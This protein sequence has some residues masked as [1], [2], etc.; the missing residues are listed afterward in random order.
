MTNTNS[1]FSLIVANIENLPSEDDFI[2]AR[3]LIAKYED[4]VLLKS[5]KSKINCPSCNHNQEIQ[6]TTL[7]QYFDYEYPYGLT[8]GDTYHFRELKEKATCNNCG[9]KYLLPIE[10]QSNREYTNRKIFKSYEKISK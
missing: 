3:N 7:I 6:D 9:N 5:K 10:I 2:A 4:G 8:G 1:T